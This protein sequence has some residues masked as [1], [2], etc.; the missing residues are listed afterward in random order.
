[1]FLGIVIPHLSSYRD[2]IDLDVSG[3]SFLAEAV[4]HDGGLPAFSPNHSLHF[5]N[6][7]PVDYD[8]T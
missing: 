1:M 6:F 5:A 3:R 4:G 8:W 7:Y 2:L